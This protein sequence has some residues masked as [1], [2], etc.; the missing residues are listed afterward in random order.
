MTF[1]VCPCDGAELA[2][3]VHLP[4]LPHIAYRVGT[5]VDFRRALLT[6]LAGEQTL[7]V[8]GAP[9]WRTTGDG[10]LAVMI[11]EWFA[12]IADI[13]TFYNERIANQDYLRTA[14]L[15]ESVAH[16]IAIL[17]YRPRP[18]IGAQGLL[19]ALVTPGQSASL[20]AGLQFQSKPAPGQSPQTFELSA[21][22]ASIG[23]P[24]QIPATPAPV[25]LAPAQS[26][27]TWTIFPHVL[28][29]PVFELFETYDAN[30]KN[31]KVVADAEIAFSGSSQAPLVQHNQSLVNARLAAP[32]TY[33]TEPDSANYTLLLR[34]AVDSIDPGAN[35]VLA[36]RDPSNGPMLAVVTKAAIAP[37]PTGGQQTKLIITLYGTPP[38]GLSAAQ[39][40]LEQANQSAALWT[41]PGLGAIDG[42]DVNLAS[43][44]RQI[45]PNDWVLFTQPSEPPLLIQVGSVSEA[46]KNI[47]TAANPVQIP[48]T[49]LTLNAALPKGWSSAATVHFGWISVGTLLDQPFSTWTG[50]PTTLVASG[51]QT[52]PQATAYPILLQDANGVG[53][54]ATA[55]STDGVGATLTLSQ[56]PSLVPRLQ[57]PFTVLPNVLTITRGKTVANEV[58]GSGDATN[59]AQSFKLKQSPVTYLQSGA[60]YASTISLTVGS[61]P[62]TEVASFYGQPADATVFV[63]SEDDAGFTHVAFGDG[64]NGARLPTG[65]NNVVA[66]YRIGAGLASPAAGKLTVI[67]QSYPGLRA[68]LNPLAVG[69]GADPDPPAQV[70]SY[71]PRSV[72]AFGRAVSVFDYEAIAA[73]T[74]SVTRA[75]AVWAWNDAAQRT[76]VTVYVGDDGAAATAATNA[77]A[78][79]GD[80][81]RPVQVLQATPVLATLALTLIT[82]NGMDPD[83]IS[84]GVVMA[85]T[86]PQAGLFG[87]A[88]LAIG[89]PVFDSQIEAAVLAVPGAVAI[90]AATFFANGAV[91][92]GPL[93][94]PGEG[95]YYVLD[96]D[97]TDITTVTE[98][99]SNGG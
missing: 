48:H 76:M 19:A 50:T 34:G 49:V 13:L 32:I 83:A 56:L 80:P 58:L 68:V 91:D 72:L 57:P 26:T 5:Y 59:P 31:F 79:A 15:P 17:G 42:Y 10:D 30:L 82:A 20:P 25:L 40:R 69:G 16:L 94:N 35:L 54:A 36:P 51:A 33:A 7:S 23:P 61:Q 43:L 60:A 6:P 28:H 63:T 55:S 74:P 27:S 46:I 66:T 93:H 44:V 18:A 95:A 4:G 45:R 78:A 53:I 24:D 62:W 41:L 89:Q 52:F 2:P 3:P 38:A 97:P 77:L 8:G 14:D 37:A 29:D 67:A 71:A 84:A 21:P 96:F 92:A 85:L 11:A 73:L 87:T 70:K 99:G 64:V 9:V 98:P 39:A 88:Q 1:P 12:Y 81:N 47:G 90:T 22:G 86:D 75:R 65:L